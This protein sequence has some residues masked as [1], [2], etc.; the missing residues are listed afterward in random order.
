MLVRDRMTQT[1]TTVSP[2]T[3]FDEAIRLM[4]ER[5]VR[6]FPV[7]D[8]HNHVVG[9]IS[10][11]DLLNAMPSPATTLSRYE[12]NE[13]LARLCVRD[14]MTHTAIVVQPDT[15]LEEAARIM[16]DNKIG[17]LPV[18]DAQHRLVGIITETDIFRTM[19]DMLGARRS[20]LRLSFRVED[21]RG[22]LAEITGEVTRQ[23]GNIITIAIFSGDNQTHPNIMLKVENVDDERLIAT[24]KGMNAEILDARR[25]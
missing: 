2:D 17:G 9:I 11:K 25:V 8:R 22:A 7:V 14:L 13:L 3:S 5:K 1:P 18:V 21:H 24:L 16:A 6:R 10:E 15:L 4:R 20:G 19:V 23:G 12:M